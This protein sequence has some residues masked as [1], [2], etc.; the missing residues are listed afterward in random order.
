M[1][2]RP[3]SLR[4]VT[5][6]DPTPEPDE[7][8]APVSVPPGQAQHRPTGAINQGPVTYKGAPL[9]AGRG[10][11][12][13]CFWSQMVALV[14]LIVLTPLSV[15]RVPDVVTA[16]LLFAT[17]GLLLVSGQTIIF[18][19][20]IVA[21]DRR[22]RREPLAPRSP[23]VGQLEEPAATDEAPSA[24]ADPAAPS[25]TDEAP[26][27]PE[28]PAAPSAGEPPIDPPTGGPVRQ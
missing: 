5:Q 14:V 20:R 9:E 1:A 12:L 13:G 26:S 18:L 16:I 3:V 28:D 24:P 23:T 21:A 8:P 19:L 11:G 22:G 15:G 27:A 2:A 10:P 4:L 17:I 25:A 7:T 6:T